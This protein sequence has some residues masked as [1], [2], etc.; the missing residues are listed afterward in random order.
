[1]KR[2]A[3]SILLIGLYLNTSAQE[4][5][6][7][8]LSDT[9]IIQNDVKPKPMNKKLYTGLDA[10]MGYMVSSKGYG[11]PFMSLS[12]YAAYPVNDKFHLTVGI[13]AGFGNIYLPYLYS[14]ENSEMLPMTQ[15]FIYARGNYML[16]EKL[17]VSG[18]AYKRIVDVKNPNR[19][20]KPSTS[21]DY[22][23]VSV[24]LNYKITNNISFGAQIH[25]DSPAYNNSIYSPFEYHAL[26]YGW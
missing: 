7:I 13:S 4:L 10:N 25:F 3:Y 1:M 18:S 8:V 6:E 15:M 12:P 19:S 14:G 20:L 21:F 22:Q 24:G 11:G 23:G 9:T 5:D 2:L 16:N 17:T 26:P